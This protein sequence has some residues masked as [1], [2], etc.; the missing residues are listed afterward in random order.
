ML[1]TETKIFSESLKKLPRNII[2]T[3]IT[4][5]TCASIAWCGARIE[6]EYNPRVGI[7]RISDTTV[8]RAITA[9]CLHV[10][11]RFNWLQCHELVRNGILN[12]ETVALPYFQKAINTLNHDRLPEELMEN[13]IHRINEFNGYERKKKKFLEENTGAYYS[14]YLCN[15]E[16]QEVAVLPFDPYK[17]TFT[18]LDPLKITGHQVSPNI[19][20][21]IPNSDERENDQNKTWVYMGNN[22]FASHANGYAIQIKLKNSETDKIMT[23]WTIGAGWLGP[24]EKWISQFGPE[25]GRICYDTLEPNDWATP[26]TGAYILNQDSSTG[27]IKVQEIHPYAGDLDDP[28]FTPEF[29]Y[30]PQGSLNIKVL[31]GNELMQVLNNPNK[32]QPGIIVQIAKHWELTRQNIEV[33]NNVKHIKQDQTLIHSNTHSVSLSTEEVQLYNQLLEEDAPLSYI[34][35]YKSTTWLLLVRVD[36]SSGREKTIIAFINRENYGPEVSSGM[37]SIIMGLDSVLEYLNKHIPNAR[38]TGATA[39][40]TGQQG[41]TAN[42]IIQKYPYEVSSNQ[43]NKP[44]INQE[45]N[46]RKPSHI[47]TYFL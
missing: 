47:Q 30:L 17:V 34:K 20:L 39:I 8:Y 10:D 2:K 44:V 35:S 22:P 24:S 36:D 23:K 41:S 14:V 13:S 27:Q 16:R 21:A 6:S 26:V 29:L 46:R 28:T 15:N 45:G 38:I 4:L 9:A 11:G 40:H 43:P 19:F 25:C 1:K 31:K 33:L 12:V 5:L 18:L 7:Q 3:F 32:Y 42:V 37:H